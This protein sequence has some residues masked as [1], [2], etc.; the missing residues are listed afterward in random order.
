MQILI[1]NTKHKFRMYIPREY[2]H[3]IYESASSLAEIMTRF[4]GFPI[5]KAE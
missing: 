5:R 2:I 4:L 1:P 3:S